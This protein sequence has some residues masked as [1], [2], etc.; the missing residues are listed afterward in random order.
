MPLS[1]YMVIFWNPI[2]P[3]YNEMLM[4]AL[5]LPNMIINYI[6]VVFNFAISFDRFQ[7][8]NGFIGKSYSFLGNEISIIL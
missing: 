7:V 5:Y 6:S 2:E 8:R 4:V 3:S 1:F